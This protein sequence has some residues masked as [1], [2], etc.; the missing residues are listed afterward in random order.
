MIEITGNIFEQ[1]DADVICFTSNGVV[2]SNGELVMGAGIAKAFKERWPELPKKFG[3]YVQMYGNYPYA[4]M[5][6][7]PKKWIANFPTKHHWKGISDINL[8]VDSAKR[9]VLMADADPGMK[10]IYL[11]RPG[12]GLGGLHWEAV[13]KPAIEK[14]LDD[15]FVVVN[16][17]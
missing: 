17:E 15:R 2:K 6:I 16:N 8:I 10:K 7:W 4:I 1:E 13:V 3:Q 14:I 5:G 11:T 12:C 9:M